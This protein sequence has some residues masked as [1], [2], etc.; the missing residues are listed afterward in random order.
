M[1]LKPKTTISEHFSA[2]ED[3]RIDRTKRHKLIDIITI[4]LCAVISGAETWEDIELFGNCKYDW[5]KSFLEL[6]NGI[7]S[8][9]TFN[10]VF[11]RLDPQQLENCFANWIRSINSLI[12]GSQIAIDGKTLRHSYDH[13]R[14]QKPIVMV[15][16]WARDSGLVLAQTKVSKKSNEITAVPEL[17][18]VLELSGAIVTLD[19]MG[20]QKKIVNQIVNQKADY[21]ITL[22]KNQTGL[23]RAVDKLFQDALSEG[24]HRYEYSVYDRHE[25]EHGRTD[26]RRYQVLNNVSNLVDTEQKWSN[27]N[28]VVHVSYL[29]QL[30]SGK[31]SLESRYFITSLSQNA[32]ELADYI[33]GHWGIENQLHWIL[34]VDF[35]E[36]SS[37]IRKD[38]APE[39]L[40]VMRH[41]ALNLL[42]QDKIS[43]GSI[44]GKRKR[45]GWDN[46]YLLS[47]LLC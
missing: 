6:A 43:S 16:A 13:N 8:H 5:F 31:T 9:D 11:A 45:A 23:Y 4:T 32:E 21:L 39:N 1:K 18:K 41:I 20:C 22:K 15:S 34:D 42:K 37:R 33:R 17:L 38:N 35:N 27:L 36:D 24:H 14:E 12:S 19:A 47:L 30:K 28:S 46:H 40:A 7:P 2:L 25:H 44:K 3:P 26:N 29:R 10:R